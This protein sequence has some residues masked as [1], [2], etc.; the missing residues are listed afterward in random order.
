[1]DDLGTKGEEMGPV[2]AADSTRAKQFQSKAPTA[3]T[4]GDS[5]IIRLE[6]GR[7]HIE[8]FLI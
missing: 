1:M 2:F 7:D 6:F 4:A 3:N 8:L 5:P